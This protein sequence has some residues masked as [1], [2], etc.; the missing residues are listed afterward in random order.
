AIVWGWTPI[1]MGPQEV[2]TPEAGVCG[3]IWEVEL[4]G[5]GLG[6]AWLDAGRTSQPVIRPRA[7]ARMRTRVVRARNVAFIFGSPFAV[8]G[9]WTGPPPQMVLGLPSFV[10]S[11]SV[12]GKA[13]SGDSNVVKGHCRVPGRQSILLT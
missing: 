7:R 3:Q 10:L 2:A 5:E 4:S 8:G 9:R 1:R 12:I 11:P 13:S 6:L